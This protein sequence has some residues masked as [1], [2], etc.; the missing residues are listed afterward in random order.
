MKNK[1]TNTSHENIKKSNGIKLNT[2]NYI[3]TI[4]AQNT[5]IIHA[6]KVF[7]VPSNGALENQTIVIEKGKIATIMNGFLNPTDVRYDQE[8]Y[9]ILDLKEQF[10]MKEGKVY[11]K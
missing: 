9:K 6:G 8:N 1:T 7:A 5:T 4:F 11:K 3:E 2:T 10:V